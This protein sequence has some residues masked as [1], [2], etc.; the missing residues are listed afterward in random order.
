[1]YCCYSFAGISWL[2]WFGRKP[3]E[4]VGSVIRSSSPH[5]AVCMPPQKRKSSGKIIFVI[6]V[7][8]WVYNC[9]FGFDWKSLMSFSYKRQSNRIPL[10]LFVKKY[11]ISNHASGMMYPDSGKWIPLLGLFFFGNI[12]WLFLL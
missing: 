2:P 8:V 11:Y 12:A 6:L 1:M 4:T 10:C 9:F 5:A 7:M 3:D